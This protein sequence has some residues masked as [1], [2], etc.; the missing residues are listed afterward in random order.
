[1]SRI[2][3]GRSVKEAG[4]GIR[5]IVSRACLKDRSLQREKKRAAFA[6]RDVKRQARR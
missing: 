3:R 6:D 4:P 1:V 2:N 5:V